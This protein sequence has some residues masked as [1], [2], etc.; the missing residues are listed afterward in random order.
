[1][2]SG[3]SD[4]KLVWLLYKWMRDKNTIPRKGDKYVLKKRLAGSSFLINPEPLFEKSL[5]PIY[6]AQYI[7]LAGRRDIV[8]YEQ[9]GTL[10]LLL[11]FYTDINFDN[12]KHNPLLNI[13]EEEITFKFEK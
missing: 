13:T 3:G 9:Y 5:D 7:K 1:M 6:V 11:S 12:I 10:S 4:V 2:L 8:L